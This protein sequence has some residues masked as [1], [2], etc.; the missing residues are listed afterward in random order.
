MFL[1][2]LCSVLDDIILGSPLENGTR[3][4]EPYFIDDTQTHTY[5]P[6]AVKLNHICKMPKVP[7]LTSQ[8]F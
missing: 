4:G 7:G 1:V 5:P 3:P 2:L 6:P 8:A